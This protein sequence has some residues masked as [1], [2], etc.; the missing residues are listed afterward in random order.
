MTT[1]A[2]EAANAEMLEQKQRLVQKLERVRR[3][4]RESSQPEAE[5]L[6]DSE[7]I[8]SGLEQELHMAM[9]RQRALRETYEA[10]IAST[11]IQL[12]Q[13][14]EQQTMSAIPEAEAQ[15]LMAIATGRREELRRMC[16]E[17]EELNSALAAPNGSKGL[18]M[19]TVEA[20]E[21]SALQ[22]QLETQQRELH[23]LGKE[24]TTISQ[25][26]NYQ[27]WQE[28]EEMTQ[29]VHCLSDEVEHM[30]RGCQ[31][32]QVCSESEILELKRERS[33]AKNRL[34][35]LL[36]E[37]KQL[38]A[39]AEMLR[40][41]TPQVSEQ[42]STHHRESC[43]QAE[44]KLKELRHMEET[45]QRQ[46]HALEQ[47]QEK[48]VEQTTLATAK[49]VGEDVPEAKCKLAE[50]ELTTSQLMAAIEEKQT[51]AAQKRQQTQQV[52]KR[53]ETLQQT[54]AELQRTSDERVLRDPQPRQT[55]QVAITI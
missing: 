4:Q 6:E 17:C 20:P 50:L 42:E 51:A 13:A 35:D 36:S 5:L 44:A 23:R 33:K 12:Q 47:D 54:F 45:K 48:L 29:E 8:H 55:R 46:I 34:D 19:L 52:L 11:E 3:Q 38:E 27:G 43:R 25:S 22:R 26:R 15:A 31:D 41:E 9:A 1:S 39:R 53:I 2:T 14:M 24:L 21:I 18:E 16:R 28:H 7:E 32:D 40:V 37:L 30:R 10:R 49:M